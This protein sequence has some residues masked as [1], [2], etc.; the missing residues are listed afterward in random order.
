VVNLLLI[1]GIEA[2]EA[3]SSGKE[4][5]R[6]LSKKNRFDMILINLFM[7]DIPGLQLADEIQKRKSDSKII[8][9]VEDNQLLKL[10]SAGPAKLSFPTILKSSANRM[11]PQ[12]LAEFSSTRDCEGK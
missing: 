1:C 5:R 4:A 7:P 2:V 11:L 3:A 8:L 12:L 9:I 6:K 10:N